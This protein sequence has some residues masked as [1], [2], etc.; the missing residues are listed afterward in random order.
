MKTSLRRLVA[1]ATISS[2]GIASIATVAIAAVAANDAA[3][4]T[5]VSSSLKVTKLPTNLTPTL[6]QAPTDTFVKFDAKC[7]GLKGGCVFGK[8]TGK[9]VMY[10]FGDS[11]AQEWLAPLVGAFGSTYKIVISFRYQCQPAEVDVQPT[12]G[13]TPDTGCASWRSSAI[14]S[15]VKAKPKVIVIAESTFR[16]KTTDGANMSTATWSTGLVTVI[17][18]LKASG[19]KIVLIGDNP[20]FQVNPS[21]CLAQNTSNVQNCTRNPATQPVEYQ[22]LSAAESNAANVSGIGYID[23]TKWFCKVSSSQTQC[24]A[25]IGNMIPY[26][27]WNHITLTYSKYLTTVL[28]TAVLK[29]MK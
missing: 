11:H 18:Q 7:A 2:V 14:S 25:V 26:F 5:A 4:A 8:T 24:P 23:T 12:P 10:V 20:A 29:Y 3:V 27:D 17:T 16:L 15:I 28:K 1:A 22:V 9:D 13:T 19:A 21:S 6:A